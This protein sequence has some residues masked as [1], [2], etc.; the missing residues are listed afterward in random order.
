ILPR[1]FL[2][3]LLLFQNPFDTCIVLGQR[4]ALFLFIRYLIFMLP[5]YDVDG[6]KVHTF[7]YYLVGI[8]I[9]VLYMGLF[10][11][12]KFQGTIGKLVM[13]IKIVGVNEQTISFPRSIFRYLVLCLLSFV[14]VFIVNFFTILFTKE[15]VA[16]QDM[17]FETRVLVRG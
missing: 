8:M 6:V 14:G 13:N 16:V 7:S 11:A 15:K 4:L 9:N 17:L 2:F 3:F 12:S 5:I 1:L 10:E